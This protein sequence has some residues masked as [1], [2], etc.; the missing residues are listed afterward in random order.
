MVHMGGIEFTTLILLLSNVFVYSDE[1]GSDDS[2]PSVLP[3][4]LPSGTTTYTAELSGKTGTIPT[5]WGLASEL[6]LIHLGKS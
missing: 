4:T 3:T 1:G 6:S 5:E 2:T